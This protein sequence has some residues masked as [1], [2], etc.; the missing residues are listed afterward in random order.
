MDLHVA[1]RTRA[2]EEGWHHGIIGNGDTYQLMTRCVHYFG[3]IQGMSRLAKDSD[4]PRRSRTGIDCMPSAPAESR[5]HGNSL[6]PLC[7]RHVPFL[8]LLL[9]PLPVRCAFHIHIH[10]L[11][12]LLLF[13]ALLPFSPCSGI[14]SLLELVRLP[15]PLDRCGL[16][17]R[18]ESFGPL[19]F[20]I[21]RDS[22]L[23]NIDERR[24]F[25]ASRLNSWYNEA[26]SSPSPCA[27][28]LPFSSSLWV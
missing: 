10:V 2:R 25:L 27:S 5:Y 11:L 21:G 14:S 24:A 26:S 23:L 1:R 4:V 13:L 9:L 19:R 22:L 12:L 20:S 8:L 7:R 28:R 16:F 18:D 3:W 17:R 15:L 6:V